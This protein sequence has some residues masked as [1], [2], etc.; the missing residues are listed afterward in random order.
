MMVDSNGLN[1]EISS[2]L[3]KHDAIHRIHHS[4]EDAL[5]AEMKEVDWK[6]MAPDDVQDTRA[7]CDQMYQS[8][9]Q[10]TFISLYSYL[11]AGIDL[12]GNAFIESYTQQI[13]KKGKVKE[14]SRGD[15]RY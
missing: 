5:T 14:G 15:S 6:R 8:L 1:S 3:K 13:G 2:L 12:I 4:A 7:F 11:E 10:A 9:R